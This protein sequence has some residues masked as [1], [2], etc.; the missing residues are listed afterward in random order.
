MAA[1]HHGFDVVQPF[2]PVVEALARGFQT[3]GDIFFGQVSADRA[4]GGFIDMHRQYLSVFVLH[5]TRQFQRLRADAVV[6]CQTDDDLL[7]HGMILPNAGLSRRVR[8]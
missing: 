4:A 6:E 8:G 1:Q 5:E 7:V 3:L 2:G